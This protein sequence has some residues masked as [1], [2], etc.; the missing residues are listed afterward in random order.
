MFKLITAVSAV[1]ALAGRAAA[2]ALT[3]SST[4]TSGGYYYSFWTDGAGSISYENLDGGR[5]T[6]TWSGDGNW[7]GGK[8]W[9]T[10]SDRAI[11]FSGTYS[12]NGNSYLSV[13][14]WTKSP[15]VEYYV[16]ENYGTYDP[17]SAATE[18]GT[19]DSDGST[20]KDS[21]RIEREPSILTAT[22]RQDTTNYEDQCAFHR[23]HIHLPAVLVGPSGSPL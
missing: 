20:C 19:V 5:Y 18:I 2:Q 12:P 10:G 17:S 15:L 3:S 1:S 21:V 8:G 6:A 14:G 16:V 13:Y 9:A 7:V 23:R 22:I 11:S 4:G